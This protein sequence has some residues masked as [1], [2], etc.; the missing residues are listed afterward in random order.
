M[1]DSKI[2]HEERSQQESEIE[3]QHEYGEDEDDEEEE[4]QEDSDFDFGKAKMDYF[5][6]RAKDI[7]MNDED[8]EYE[9]NAMQ[10]GMCF[11]YLK[12]SIRNP[13][14]VHA[15]SEEKPH[16]LKMTFSTAR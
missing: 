13:V 6:Q 15:S 11:K 1:G 4:E 8:V 3:A 10:L 7:L 14:V 12:N 5:K 9:G 16:Y 2:I